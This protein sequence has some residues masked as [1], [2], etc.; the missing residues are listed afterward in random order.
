MALFPF[1][2]ET[3]LDRIIKLVGIPLRYE[4]NKK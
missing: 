1:P 4:I 2:F 3:R